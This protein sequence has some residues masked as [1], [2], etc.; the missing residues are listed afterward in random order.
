[1]LAIVEGALRS[2]K[3]HQGSGSILMS[4]GDTYLCIVT[5][6]SRARSAETKRQQDTDRVCQLA[7]ARSGA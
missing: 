1:L 7:A 4:P 3:I 6:P 5:P 2:Y